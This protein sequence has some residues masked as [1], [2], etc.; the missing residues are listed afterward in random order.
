MSRKSLREKYPEMYDIPEP[1]WTT[2]TADMTYLSYSGLFT[3]QKVAVRPGPRLTSYSAFL[4][5]D[6]GQNS[7]NST[8]PGKLFRCY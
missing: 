3:L 7:V 8:H 1:T 6:K 2:G 4:K 5:H